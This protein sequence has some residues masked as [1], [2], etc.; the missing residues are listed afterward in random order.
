MSE[1]AWF[2]GG[3]IV[4]FCI[5]YGLHLLA[6]GTLKDLF[7]NLDAKYNSLVNIIS[8]WQKKM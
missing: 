5:M 7:I 6:F 1:S 4:G 2:F 3:C 8:Q